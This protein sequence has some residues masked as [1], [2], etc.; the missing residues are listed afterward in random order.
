MI[1][2]QFEFWN[3][4]PKVRLR[5]QCESRDTESLSSKTFSLLTIQQRAGVI[6]VLLYKDVVV[7]KTISKCSWRAII[8]PP[9]I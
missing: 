2:L 8:Y 6:L 4:Q 3:V 9:A 7:Y 5:L 1:M